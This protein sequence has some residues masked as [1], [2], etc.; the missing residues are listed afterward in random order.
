MYRELQCFMGYS[1]Q[2]NLSYG[3]ERQMAYCF[4]L[5]R[6]LFQL[7]SLFFGLIYSIQE[8]STV[9]FHLLLKTSILKPYIYQCILYMYLTD[10]CIFFL[11]CI[12]TFLRLNEMRNICFP[13]PDK[14]TLL[15]SLLG[16]SRT[17][18]FRKHLKFKNL[19]TLMKTT[20]L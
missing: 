16:Y 3:N 13:L 6:W 10:F 11:V 14:T 5:K 19:E 8:L 17:S 20:Y 1:K 15:F 12:S 4:H 7:H 18:N 9:S 2:D